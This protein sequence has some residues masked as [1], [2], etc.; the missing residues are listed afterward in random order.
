VDEDTW[1][2][3][4]VAEGFMIKPLITNKVYGIDV[5][6]ML[7]RV[8]KGVQVTEH[9]REGSIDVLFPLVGRATIWVN[10]TEGFDLKPGIIVCVQKGTKHQIGDVSKGLLLF[11]DFSSALIYIR[12]RP[13][14]QE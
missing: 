9:T 13:Y 8:P 5:T 6:C 3:H 7:V 14:Y 10:G 12:R 11:D 4:P 1:V 2:C